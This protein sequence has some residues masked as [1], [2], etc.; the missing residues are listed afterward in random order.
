MTVFLHK[1]FRRFGKWCCQQQKCSLSI[2]LMVTT[3]CLQRL[4]AAHTLH[5]DQYQNAPYD[6][7]LL[8]IWHRC[9]YRN[10]WTAEIFIL[11]DTIILAVWAWAD[12]GNK[13]ILQLEGNSINIFSAFHC[14][15]MYFCKNISQVKFTLTSFTVNYLHISFQFLCFLKIIFLV[16]TL[17][18]AKHNCFS[19]FPLKLSG[20]NKNCLPIIFAIS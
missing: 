1:I 4:R 7:H 2:I 10:L 14:K 13:D 12:I 20:F 9:T 3:F 8:K 11:Q 19:I 18:F 16:S 5:L 6:L 17:S 15:K